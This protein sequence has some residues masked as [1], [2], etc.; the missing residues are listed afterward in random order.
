MGQPEY[1]LEMDHITKEYSGNQVL[2]GISLAL[3]P[4]EVLALVGENGA[5]K[6]TLMNVLFGMP[7]IHKTGGFGGNVRF[8]GHDVVIQSPH[9]AMELG[10]GMV[11][12]EFM[13][14]PEFTIAENIKLN[15]EIL[16]PGLLS[17]AAGGKLDILDRGAMNRDARADLDVLGLPLDETL[18]IEGLPVGHMQFVE[19]AREI[20]KEG[21]KLIVFD[22]PTAV[23]A[24]SEA[25]KLLDAIERLAKKGV[26][27]IFISHKLDEV[28]R[29]S[30]KIL[31][32]RDGEQVCVL[33]TADTNVIELSEKMVGREIDAGQLAKAREIPDD[34]VM[35]IKNLSV[36]M[37]GEEVKNLTIDI[38]KGEILGFGGLAG[39]GKIGIANGIMGLYPAEGEVSFHG[40][41]MDMK[42]PMDALSKGIGFVS[43]DRRG[44]GLLLGDSIENNIAITA[45]KVNG[46]FLKRYGFFSQIDRKS[47]RHYAETMIQEF[48]IKCSGP[49][50]HTGAL[51]GGNQQKVCIAR[52]LAMSP[53]ILFVSEPTRGIDIGAKQILLDYLVKLNREQGMTIVITSSELKELRSVCDRIAIIAS[54]QLE[55][56]LRPDSSDLDFGLMLSGEYKKHYGKGERVHE[57]ETS[58]RT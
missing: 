16:K 17:H 19:I 43:E 33:D 34:Y 38:R 37:P 10:I 46:T 49:G 45:M 55:G 58:K 32:M 23:L 24:E 57:N 39:H 53:E 48:R 14:L 42:S 50:Q 3:K 22:E 7:V 26:A 51:S 27:I 2:K 6:S 35:S 13:L 20:D 47:I 8:Q 28:M 44:I 29:I 31:I 11:H 9:H 25:E 18:K 40:K 54:G 12:Q 36:A 30:N 52:A 4:G 41:K 5:G 15:R 1:V 21:I 56:I